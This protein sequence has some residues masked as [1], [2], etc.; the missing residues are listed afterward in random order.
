MQLSVPYIPDPAYTDFLADHHHSLAS[1][2]F[3]LDGGG[4]WDA[5]VRPGAGHH[6]SDPVTAMARELIRLK[7][8]KNYV[9]INTRFVRPETYTDTRLLTGFLDSLARLG[10]TI[11]IQGI[12]FSDF[13]LLRALDRTGHGILGHMEAIPGVNC[14]MDTMEKV[15]ACLDMVSLT[16][17]RSPSRLI[18][19]RS[20]NR[21]PRHLAAI[22]EQI[23]T[24]YPGMSI[25]LLANEGCILHCPFKSAHDA[26]IALSN[27]G[28]VKEDTCRIN[29]YT[30][31]QDYFLA[32][33]ARFLKSPFIRP[34]DTGH[35]KGIADTFK[36]SG[37]TLGP[38]F[39]IRCIKAYLSGNY[40]GNLLDLM[41]ATHF[42]SDHFHLHNPG[43]GDDFFPLLSS[44]TNQCKI[45]KLCDRLFQRSARKQSATLRP[46]KDI[47]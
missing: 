13:Y 4:V 24:E 44:C 18:L 25:E 27:T 16:R 22:Q 36:L 30:G 1:V 21:I 17:F 32:H 47:Q 7:G 33:P 31:C 14:Q 37:R 19:D 3:P 6:A 46:F 40:D 38:A 34:E 23:S 12:V 42:L 35:Y 9:L 41:D 39:L 5:R 26:H 20:L 8:V 28:L 29:R 2:Y 45:C 15:R 43:L 11:E 10:E